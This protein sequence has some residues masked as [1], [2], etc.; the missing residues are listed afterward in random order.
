VRW[1]KEIKWVSLAALRQ[2]GPGKQGCYLSHPVSNP[3][4]PFPQLDFVEEDSMALLLVLLVL[5]PLWENLDG[6]GRLTT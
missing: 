2:K 5:R 1:I 6:K 4:A 3:L